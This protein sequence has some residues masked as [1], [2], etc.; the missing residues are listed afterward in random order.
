MKRVENLKIIYLS[1]VGKC[2]LLKIIVEHSNL[3]NGK[4]SKLKLKKMT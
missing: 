2:N 4:H 3:K 1:K